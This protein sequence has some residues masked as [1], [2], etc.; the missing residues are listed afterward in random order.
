MSSD[1]RFSFVLA[2][3][4]AATVVLGVSQMRRPVVGGLPDP[5]RVGRTAADFPIG[6]ALDGPEPEEERDEEALR[7]EDRVRALLRTHDWP[8]FASNGKISAPP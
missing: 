3:I 8:P 6:P 5:P 1:D 4:L 2:S 7:G